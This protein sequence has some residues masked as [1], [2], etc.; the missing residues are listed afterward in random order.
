[1]GPGAVPTGA[2]SSPSARTPASSSTSRPSAPSATST[3]APASAMSRSRSRRR[4]P[5]TA[6]CAAGTSSGL[7]PAVARRCASTSPAP[8]FPAHRRIRG[9][10]SSAPRVGRLEA[11][12]DS[13][14]RRRATLA[15]VPARSGGSRE[16]PVRRHRLREAVD[17]PA[18][19]SRSRALNKRMRPRRAVGAVSQLLWNISNIPQRRSRCRQDRR[20]AWARSG[21]ASFGIATK[22]ASTQFSGEAKAVVIV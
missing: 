14:W 12:W 10:C 18:E 11:A 4:S 15:E 13:F 6:P 1:M 16:E 8:P 17:D 21:L 3:S 7:R 19:V 9:S 22:R 2:S 20:S 5:T